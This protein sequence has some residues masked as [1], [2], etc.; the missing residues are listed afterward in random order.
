VGLWLATA[1]AAWGRTDA[2]GAPLGWRVA[3]PVIGLV[4]GAVVA[5]GVVGRRPRT[6]H[7]MQ[8]AAGSASGIVLA[9]GERAMWAHRTFLVW[10]LAL[11]GLLGVVAVGLWF[12]SGAPVALLVVAVALG[13]GL[14]A[15]VQVTVDP[16]GLTIGLGPWAWAVKKVELATIAGASAEPILASEWGGW[17]YRIM[18]GRSALVLRSGPAIV[19]DLTDGRRFAVTVDGPQAPV[20][21]LDA[22][23]AREVS[24]REVSAR[25]RPAGGS[26]RPGPEA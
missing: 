18:P 6:V 5:A 7:V 26:V 8:V 14:L 1:H 17:G 15:W 20:A 3:L 21:L 11:A 24:A 25:A 16:R 22:L 23:L 4:A 10:P 12:T 2:V 19:L 9:P 13:A